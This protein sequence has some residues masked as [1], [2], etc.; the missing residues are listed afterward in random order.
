M[1][2]SCWAIWRVITCSPL[3]LRIYF[4]NTT[5]YLLF[6]LSKT[7]PN[8]CS[9]C[10]V[11]SFL[12]PSH[13][14]VMLST[15]K[16]VPASSLSRPSKFLTLQFLEKCCILHSIFK[17]LSKWH[18]LDIFF[19]SKCV[20]QIYTSIELTSGTLIIKIKNSICPCSV[21]SRVFIY[22]SNKPLCG[23]LRIK[24]GKNSIYACYCKQIKTFFARIK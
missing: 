21:V 12:S 7:L 3:T 11:W 6:L 1:I 10:S 17:I 15:H 22:A 2:F 9:Q 20:L 4:V 16:Y 5:Q 8:I 18:M 14:K 19:N 23:T 24:L 13:L